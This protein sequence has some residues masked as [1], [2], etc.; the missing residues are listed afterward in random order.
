[1][2]RNR[3]E[4][5]AGI[6]RYCRRVSE[7]PET[8]GPRLRLHLVALFLPPL[9]LLSHYH[10][11]FLDFERLSHGLDHV[12]LPFGEIH[13]LVDTRNHNGLDI[14]VNLLHSLQKLQ[15]VDVGHFQI[16]GR[17]VDRLIREDS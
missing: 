7:T 1:L 15:S 8:S 17:K 2:L 11:Q 10:S 9:E 14:R 12:A 6:G 16:D 13:D 3:Q 4:A 5:E